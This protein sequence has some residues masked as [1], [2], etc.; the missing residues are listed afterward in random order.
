MA[1][2]ITILS[3]GE[4]RSIEVPVE[5]GTFTID[6]N[7]EQRRS[8]EL[9]AVIPATVPPQTQV[10]DG[11]AVPFLPLTPSSPLAPFGPEVNIELA[12][13]S[14]GQAKGVNGWVPYGVYTIATSTINDITTDLTVTLDLYDRSWQFSQWG[15]L[16]NYTV[17]ATASGTLEDEVVALLTYVWNNN[18]P[19]QSGTPAPAWLTN[20]NVVGD[21]EWLVPSG[22]LNQGQDPWQACLQWGVSA[23]VE[24]FFDVNGV[25]TAKNVPGTPNGGSLNSQP[26]VW[27]FNPSEV[28]AIGTLQHALWGTPYTTPSAI[29]LQM[30]RDGVQNDFVVTASGATNAV[31]STTQPTAQAMD[32]NTASPTYIKGAMGRVPSFVYDSQI[33]TSTQASAEAAYDLALA[34]SSAWT[35]SVIHPPNPL[36]DVDDVMTVTDPR[37]ALADQKFITDTVTTS[38][39]YDGQVTI[40]GRIITAGM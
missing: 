19:G 33:T 24:L 5:D 28:S 3:G 29:T 39:R 8:G 31:A 6:R 13:M 36:W 40:G 4:P 16:Q 38:I 14:A 35:V 37:L 2:R 1:A 32:T 22:T 21:V 15:L 25:L 10:Y 26:V 9:T 18:G 12:V 23:G 34:I 11:V 17:P 30:T 27:G 20:P 7:S